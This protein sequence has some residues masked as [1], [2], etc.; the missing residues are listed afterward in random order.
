MQGAVA[1]RR[2]LGSL[3]KR[4]HAVVFE[5]DGALLQDAGSRLVGSVLGFLGAVI[6]RLVVVGS[7]LLGT[8]RVLYRLSALAKQ[9]TER[10]RK[11][12]ASDRQQQGHDQHQRHRHHRER[13]ELTRP[14][15]QTCT[16]LLTR[17]SLSF[18]Q[19]TFCL[20]SSETIGRSAPRSVLLTPARQILA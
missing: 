16:L 4:Q 10:R 19:Q 2:H 6:L 20:L 5:Q 11:C 14:H 8:L 12:R 9:G 13:E 1:V 18:R 15:A 7:A 3:R 17:H